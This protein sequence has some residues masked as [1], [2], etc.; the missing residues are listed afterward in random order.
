MKKISIPIL[1]L[2]LLTQLLFPTSV[3]A[4]IGPLCWDPDIWV[5]PTSIDFGLVQVGSESSP[6]TAT[7]RNVGYGDLEIGS[8]TIVGD[9]ASQF[10]KFDDNAEGATLGR[11]ESETL[12]VKFSPTSTGDKSA[13]LKIVSND[14]D[15]DPFYV[16]LSGTGTAPP[17]PDIDVDPLTVPFGS[18]EQGSPSASQNVTV[19]N[20][21]TANLNIT[22][23]TINDPQFA[24]TSGNISGQIIPPG[25]SA[26]ITLVFTPSA[27][28]PQTAAMTITSNDPDE[29]SVDVSLSG[30]GSVTVH[31]TV[32]EDLNGNGVQDSGETG[33]SGVTV[34]LDGTNETTNPSGQYS[35]DVTS[36]GIYTVAE[37]DP[38]GY[39]ST[40]P[41]TVYIN[42]GLASSY[43]VDFGDAPA[44]PPTFAVIYGTVFEDLNGN[45]VQDGEIGIPGVTVSLDGIDKTT[46][47]WGMYTF[48]VDTAGSYTVVETD[49]AGYF[50][51]TP[52]SV[53]VNVEIGHSYVVNFGDTLQAPDISVTPLSLGFGSVVQGTS[54]AENV[55][56]TNTGDAILNI[57]GITI[58]DGQFAITSG[59]ISGQT[60]APGDSANITIVF[61]P[62]AAGPQ[63]ATMTITSNDPDEGTVDVSLS[64]TG[65]APPAPDIDVDPLTVPFGSV[66]LGSSS[67]S[68]NVTV[69]NT[70]TA[71]LNITGI[72]INDPQFAI[73]SG[74]ISGQTLAPGDSANITIVFTP[75]AAGPQTGT[76]TITSNDPD[77][78]TVGVSLSGTGTTP[79]APDID[80][81]PLTVPFGSVELGSSS[82]SQNVT[83]TNTGTAD[84]NITGIT[85]NDPQ[86]A[87]TSGNISG[88]TLAPG[89][90][91]N[92]TIVFTPS[93]TGPQ[94]GTMTITSNDPDEGTVIVPLNGIGSEGTSADL[95][96]TKAGT[97]DPVAYGE[98]LTYTLTVINNGPA[99]ATGISVTDNLSEFVEYLSH[100]ASAGS[101][102][103]TLG[104]IVTWNIDGLASGANVTLEIVTKFRSGLLVSGLP[105]P[106]T[107]TAA[108]SGN[109]EDPVPGNNTAS[110][111]TD[112][113]SAD[114]VITK[115]D[116]AD[117]VGLDDNFTWVVTVINNGPHNATDVVVMDA[118]IPELT[119]IHNIETSNGT[120]VETPPQWLTDLFQE[121]G[122]TPTAT[123]ML[124]WEIGD[125]ASGASENMT[126]TA[127]TNAT[128]LLPYADT[129]DALL[130]LDGAFGTP[131]E[132]MIPVPDLATVLSTTF[133]PDFSNN[134]ATETTTSQLDPELPEADLEITK[135]YSP[136]P[137]APD[138]TITYV[139]TIKNNG[140]EDATDVFVLDQWTESQLLSPTATPSKGTVNQT[141][142]QWLLD[143][144]SQL[145]GTLS[146]GV[147]FFYWDVGDLANGAS[148]NM[149][150]V[151]NVNPDVTEDMPY[152][153]NMALVTGRVMDPDFLGNNIAIAI[154]NIGTADLGITKT[155]DPSPVAASGNI[156]Y[157]L[158]VTNNGPTTAANVTVTDTLPAGVTF[159]S[160]VPS[161]GTTDNSSNVVTWDVGDLA[162]G[163]SANLTI[164]A[165]VQTEPGAT[166]SNTATVYGAY[167][168]PNPD[169]D[170]DSTTT[171]VVSSEE[172][173]IEITKIDMPDPVAVGGTLT[174]VLTV[175]N[176]G[177]ADASMIFVT[178]TLPAGVTFQSATPSQGTADNTSNIVDWDV[179][180]LAYKASAN[181]TIVVTAPE[182]PGVI[183]NTATVYGE[184]DEADETNN[185]ITE[186]TTVTEITDADLVI[187]KIDMPD[188]VD[189]T[190]DMTYVLTVTNNGPA[191]ATS[192]NVTDTLPPGVTFK[193]TTP[194][195]G[196]YD[197]SLGTVTWNIGD[198]AVGAS[199]SLT[200]LVAAP[201]YEGV[202]TNT[203]AVTGAEDDPVEENNIATASTRVIRPVTPKIID[204]TITKSDD[205]DPVIT[206]ENLTYTLTVGN[207]GPDAAYG[208]TVTDFL[209]PGT[210]FVSA[211]PS[212]WIYD[213]PDHTVIWD[214]GDLAMGASVTLTV[215]VTAPADPGV[216][217]NT[218][219]VIHQPVEILQVGGTPIDSNPFNNMTLAFTTVWP[220]GFELPEIEVTPLS[221]DF[222]PTRVG[223]SESEIVT[224]KNNG[225]ASL[226]LHQITISNDQF[227]I[228]AND[229]SNT[230][231]APGES[232]NMTL[233][234]SPTSIGVKTGV[235]TIPSNDLDEQYVVV[236]LSGTGTRGG[237]GGG[238]GGDGEVTRYF[239]VN[240]LGKITQQ[241]A[242][243]EGRPLQT[244]VAP[245]PDG[246]HVL[247]IPA[248]TSATD[249]IGN[250]V[251][252]I[253][254]RETTASDLPRNTVLIGSAYEF[255]PSGTIFDQSVSLTLAYDVNALPERV[256]SVG[257]AYYVVGE[258]WIYL[259]KETEGVAELGRVTSPVNHFTVFA[260]LA[261]SEPAPPII[262][263]PTT[264]T[265][266]PAPPEPTPPPPP[267]PP[268]SL[269]AFFR[270]GNLTIVTSEFRTFENIPYYIRT[271]ENADISVDVTNTGEQAG[272]HMVILVVNGIER[273]RQLVSLEPGETKTVLFTLTDV[274]PGS[275]DVQIGDQDGNFLSEVWINWWLSFGSLAAI[276]LIALGLFFLL[277]AKRRRKKSEETPAPAEE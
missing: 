46:N 149:T 275:Y 114:L 244:I 14:P 119:Q 20:T 260:V 69:T 100:N 6:E 274:E 147:E 229:A 171:K 190:K 160:A 38:P 49:P 139:V 129:L 5:T 182:E 264:T 255:T 28:G 239:T 210:T 202:I 214:I 116:T 10:I 84:L 138:G 242:D 212:G 51:I 184:Y 161:Q 72:T 132:M 85:I 33:I 122:I 124:Y 18:I 276:I 237:N 231:L 23:I 199:S 163:A 241:E 192:V 30:I 53:N 152:I 213:S 73:T 216:I 211:E 40:T 78:G 268:E 143:V 104:G 70:G 238:G 245:S 223:S 80:V 145:G 277:A 118:Y 198:L 42:V 128:L 142:P 269:P 47:I 24:I 141:L 134:M 151:A 206:G 123:P 250:Q 197:D 251:T 61:T 201:G 175:T 22:G 254:I 243:E 162:Y 131:P 97:P 115:V 81:D 58:D 173:D 240:F 265:E 126:V 8:I 230:S 247:T 263:P 188:P 55:T 106:I 74:N 108:V 183:T 153:V 246:A 82:A 52:N 273:D 121:V 34:S 44:S 167:P 180:D 89:A 31:G 91:E 109:E 13:S 148:A 19:T 195:V 88:Q 1:L 178:D 150:I 2:V 102:N 272:S 219:N 232:V 48:K 208:V 226:A 225:T 77:E 191:T 9:D 204:L 140:P 92:I 111:D 39:F 136:D 37:I 94:T 144:M 32:F 168:D 235:M 224:I 105:S 130:R 62:S 158:I 17:A 90:S 15:E 220:P 63:S 117:P 135:T 65:T 120:I 270:L 165:S 271:G 217:M 67:A 252:L 234:F 107:N 257:T 7:I 101:V 221:V 27:S 25:D 200:I 60:L 68:Q 79:P 54:A 253:E 248:G 157:T 86:F 16:P 227:R 96:I 172:S 196:I 64:G 93:A 222:E 146:D 218:A 193:S 103:V 256:T 174:Y 207:N 154:T 36:P 95:A 50:S 189:A 156:T 21:G 57:T 159:Q 215:R 169:N 233:V 133:D 209:P 11:C 261:E 166:L 186:D 249:G 43:Q 155:G 83:V 181:L 127:S 267:P 110:E 66:E 112:L 258:G 194:P 262:P 71:D 137:V 98:N 266:P 179:G 41:N 99:Y 29:A 45:G 170:T 176:N 26:N 113:V 164:V 228:T 35:F 12:K 59:N 177:P 203:A 185:D 125:L 76:M 259:I 3:A 187:T 4:T 75:S 205:P 87:I 56:V 236:S